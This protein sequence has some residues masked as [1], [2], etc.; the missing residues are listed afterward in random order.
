MH[1]KSDNLNLIGSA[2]AG[3]PGIII[4][5]NQKISWGVTNVG[6]DIQDLYIIDEDKDGESY[7]VDGKKY[8]YETRM[9]YINVKGS[10]QP[11]ELVVRS[12]I[13]GPVIGPNYL[14]LDSALNGY[15][16]QLKEPVALRWVALDKNE[17]T[18]SAFNAVMRASNFEEFRNAL[19]LYMAPAQNFVYADVD[20]NIGYQCTGVTPI[21]K[22]GHSGAFPVRSNSSFQWQGFHDFQRLPWVLN[23]PEQMIVTANN[24]VNPYDFDVPMILNDAEWDPPSRATRIQRMIQEKPL[25][26]ITVQ[27][28]MQMQ[29]DVVSLRFQDALV[30][31]HRINN[32]LNFHPSP[33]ATNSSLSGLTTRWLQTLLSWDGNMT[34]SS[35]E[36]TVFN[37]WLRE[38]SKLPAKELS[39]PYWSNYL[40]LNNTIFSQRTQDIACNDYINK[41][42]EIDCDVFALDAL[43]QV[44]ANV[45]SNFSQRILNTEVD[46]AKS[47]PPAWGE[48][49]LLHLSHSLLGDTPLGCIYGRTVQFGGDS[50]TV[51]VGPANFDDLSVEYGPSY[52]QIVDMSDFDSSVFIHPMGQSEN[53]FEFSFDNYLPLWSNFQYIDMHTTQY[54][55]NQK[56]ILNK[57][58]K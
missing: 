31:L 2:F 49:H 42:G 38:L 48:L 32:K 20:G 40:W 8:R 41:F 28:V 11:L 7:W 55:V 16:K 17:T 15:Y 34:R 9:E 22:N 39:Q 6:T 56:M 14:S 5:H 47:E 19:S 21:R 46:L 54:Q 29:S 53:P 37:L 57:R 23:P 26:S 45:V 33:L 35:T 58:V 44:L 3:V 13:L 1:L 12:T 4:G 10:S 50:E 25:H 36:A 30:L 18:L 52:R 51:A 24:K 27:D 43:E